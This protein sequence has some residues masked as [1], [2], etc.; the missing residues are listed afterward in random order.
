MKIGCLH[1]ILGVLVVFSKNWS[2]FFWAYTP[3]HT[4]TRVNSPRDCMEGFAINSEF[5]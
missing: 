3:R 1:V 5:F 2:F 4:A